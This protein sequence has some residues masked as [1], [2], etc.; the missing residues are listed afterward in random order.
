MKKT[1]R[2][3]FN[4]KDRAQNVCNLIESNF[5]KSEC[6]MTGGILGFS[7]VLPFN[8]NGASNFYPAFPENI[9][10]EELSESRTVTVSVKCPAANAAE[11]ITC[12]IKNGG[13]IQSR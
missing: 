8:S 13:E 6:S 4:D 2:A 7:G 9:T 12:L 11:I 1:I 3:T 10:S 5:A